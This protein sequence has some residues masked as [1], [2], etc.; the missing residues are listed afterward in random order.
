M[1]DEEVTGQGTAYALDLAGR[2]LRAEGS[3]GAE[4]YTYD[5]SGN[6]LTAQWPQ[7]AATRPHAANGTTPAPACCAPDTS[8]TATTPP[9]AS[10]NA[11]KKRLSRKPD[12]WRYTWDAEDR[13]TSCVIPDATARTPPRHLGQHSDHETGL[14]Y[15]LFRHHSPETARY[16]SPYPLGF[17][18]RRPRSPTSTTRWTCTTRSA[19][20]RAAR[21]TTPGATA[22][23]D[24]AAA[25]VT[26]RTT[27]RRPTG[28]S[29]RIRPRDTGHRHRGGRHPAPGWCGNGNAF[30]EARGHPLA[31]RLGGAGTRHNTGHNLVAQTNDPTNSPYQRDPVEYTPYGNRGF[32]LAGRLGNPAAGVRTAIPGWRS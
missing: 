11:S 18:P 23:A 21:I 15:N 20:P 2:P 10:S 22:L 24:A 30:N 12:V 7:C 19:R 4:T 32:E 28:V 17:C 13:L 1:H 31:N 8:T 6:V 29:A 9:D 26:S 3:A 27:P 14:F 25:S 16:V 5:A